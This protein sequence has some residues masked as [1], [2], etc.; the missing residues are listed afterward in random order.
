MITSEFVMYILA[1]VVG[2]LTGLLIGFKKYL[3]N[4]DSKD[5]GEDGDTY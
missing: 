1:Y 5:D 4:V 3:N 2:L